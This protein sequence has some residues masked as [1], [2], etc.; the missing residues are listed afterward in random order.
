MR[1]ARRAWWALLELR[2]ELAVGAHGGDR[3][4]ALRTWL[5]GVG[6]HWPIRWSEHAYPGSYDPPRPPEPG[7][8]CEWCG[9]PRYPYRAWW[10]RLEER[11]WWWLEERAG[12]RSR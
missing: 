6:L 9:H 7:F 10:W 2:D 11:V 1:W 12:R 4:W 8:G 3:R 5:C